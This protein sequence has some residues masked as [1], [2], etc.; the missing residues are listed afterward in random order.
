[1][2]Q[3]CSTKN[4][5]RLLELTVSNDQLT[6]LYDSNI[7][8]NNKNTLKKVTSLNTSRLETK[9]KSNTCQKTYKVKL[10]N[11]KKHQNAFST[12]YNELKMSYE[13]I[14]KF[15]KDSLSDNNISEFGELEELD[16]IVNTIY[17]Y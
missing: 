1:M 10:S 16:Y 8:E 11:Y 3:N 17:F 14:K 7:L 13:S 5:N 4:E 12:A 2:S 15:K 9:Y 6:Q